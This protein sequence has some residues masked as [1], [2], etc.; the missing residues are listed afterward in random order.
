MS[1]SS[2]PNGKVHRALAVDLPFA[3]GGP[4]GQGRLRVEPEDFRV[5]EVPICEPD[6]AGEHAWLW[7]RKRNANTDWVARQLARFAGVTPRDVSFA[8]M[9]DRRAVTE[10]WFSVQLPGRADPDW[11]MLNA[12]GVE[13]R[14]AERHSRK[15]KRGALRGNDFDIRVRALT[16]DRDLI[17][18]RLNAI[19]QRGI[20]NYF[21]SQRFG[22]EGQN[23][24][25]ADAMLRGEG[26]RPERHVRGLFLSA[27]RSFLFNRVL[28]TRVQAASWE[29]AIAGDVI[30]L[31]GSRAW[32]LADPT[33]TSLAQR[34]VQLD[35]HPTGPLWGRGTLATADA[36]RELELACMADWADW[37]V[38]LERAGLEQDRR[39]LRVKALDLRWAWSSEGDLLLHFGLP[40]GSYATILVREL[41]HC[42]ID[43][44][45]A[46]AP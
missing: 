43:L 17:D 1:D 32:F 27:A 18:A 5:R 41:M 35:V 23:I 21:G 12:E 40:P 6:G 20:P 46:D 9:K 34:L 45:E 25:G 36:A 8:G 10:Q 4:V 19:A 28:A 15:L 7:I 14:R 2:A 44:D 24:A 30:Q 11:S 3:F 26:R 16:G 22:R 37:C 13:V 39:A 33:D 38:G 31:N 29:H 42:G